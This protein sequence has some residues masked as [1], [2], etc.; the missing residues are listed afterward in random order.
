[1]EDQM[2]ATTKAELA[3]ATLKSPVGELRLAA[4]DDGLVA[5]VFPDEKKKRVFANAKGSAEAHA[6]VDAAVAALKEYF[7][8]N[9]T[10]FK[11]I[12]LAPEGTAFQKS[13][14]KA[15]MK[16]PFGATKSYADIA[17]AIGNPKAMRA[18]G[19]ANGRNPIPIIV[20][21][22]RVI[23]ANGALTGFGG[24]IPTKK[25]LLEHEG[26]TTPSLL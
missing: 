15:L 19:L 17:R 12:K 22:H 7:A 10:D 4:S 24:G 18:V 13:V 2:K 9:R 1:M 6:H 8:G 23:G 21:C 20:P 11:D 3:T 25:A 5:V 16:I 26:V 14:W